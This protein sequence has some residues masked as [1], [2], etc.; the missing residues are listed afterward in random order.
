MKTKYKIV[1]L[2]A[3]IAVFAI[4]V[5]AINSQV[6]SKNEHQNLNIG[7]SANPTLASA[8]QDSGNGVTGANLHYNGY[9]TVWKTEAATGKKTLVL[10]HK[11]NQITTIGQA[12]I[13]N[14]LNA[15][16]INNSNR[17]LAMV[18]AS[19]G[20]TPDASWTKISD[21]LTTNGFSRNTTGTYTVN[22]TNGY[23]VSASWTATGTQN[24]VQLTGLQWNNASQSD[25]NLFAAV[26]FGNQSMMV[27]DILTA[28]WQITIN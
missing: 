9:V 18:V 12:F 26:S 25:G 28:T 20:T 14:K 22:G 24:N 10:D 17:T 11:H 27:N 4:V 8:S 23:N 6:V 19:N 16:D 13:V 1:T 3:V 2:L 7:N 21:E 5:T 15:Q